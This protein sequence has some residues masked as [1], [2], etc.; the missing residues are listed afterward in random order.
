MPT[1]EH[2]RPARDWGA[3]AGAWGAP[4]R[5]TLHDIVPPGTPDPDL[6]PDRLPSTSPFGD[7]FGPIT[8][9]FDHFFGE[10]RPLLPAPKPQPA[11]KPKPQPQ[12]LPFGLT[13]L[14]FG[15]PWPF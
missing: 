6:G 11:P 12:P 2:V 13:P 14:P 4:S 9:L 15:F 3:P 8:D 10:E 5:G 1:D 7:L